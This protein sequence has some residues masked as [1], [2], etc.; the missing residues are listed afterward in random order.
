MSPPLAPDPTFLA[1]AQVHLRASRRGEIAVA[2]AFATYRK[3]CRRT[4]RGPLSRANFGAAL[5]ALARP[6]GGCRAGETI[7]A[8][9]LSDG[10]AVPACEAIRTAAAPPPMPSAQR[11]SRPLPSPQPDLVER[12]AATAARPVPPILAV[13]TRTAP[14]PIAP[15]V[16][17]VTVATPADPVADFLAT[18]L[19]E[20]PGF[21]VA[22]ESLRAAAR[23]ED[24]RFSDVLERARARG[25]AIRKNAWGPDFLTDARLVEPGAPASGLPLKGGAENRENRA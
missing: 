11:L 18:R 22:L 13:A 24:L 20:A 6:L 7:T 16:P 12:H 4:R 10:E 1:F 19:I 21:V 25:H 15:P 14:R 2:S 17:I 8:L 9:A 3:F 5:L 23:A